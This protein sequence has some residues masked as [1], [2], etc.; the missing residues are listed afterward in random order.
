MYF[1]VDLQ[2]IHL[3]FN[4]Q[5]L[6]NEKCRSFTGKC[7]EMKCSPFKLLSYKL[8][9]FYLIAKFLYKNHLAIAAFRMQ[10]P[11]HSKLCEQLAAYAEVVSS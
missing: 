10:P 8:T 6:P 9:F 11:G 2:F 3:C 1:S 7:F 4:E 5:R